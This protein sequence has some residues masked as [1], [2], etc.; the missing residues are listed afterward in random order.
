[1]EQYSV[2]VAADLPYPADVEALVNRIGSIIDGVKIGVPT[3]LQAGAGFLRKIR[4]AVAPKPILVDLKIADI[5]FRGKTGWEGTNAKILR[6]LEN[7]GATHVTVHGFPGF[8]SAAEAV[9]VAHDMGI[10]VLLLPIMS[11][12]GADL[13]FSRPLQEDELVSRCPETGSVSRRVNR[14]ICSDVTDGIVML[15]EAINTD[16]YIGPSTSPAVLERLRELT[17]RPIWCP[18]FGRQ[19]RR[20]RDLRLQFRDWAKALGPRS[21]AIVGSFILTASDQ[22]SAARH[23]IETRDIAVESLR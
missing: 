21:T 14:P 5:G 15:G 4:D 17:S 16:G 18:G 3:L 11:H 12:M 19:D 22:V 7:T 6:S 23:I 2:I 10:S 9:S 20:G 8:V 1:M 13:F